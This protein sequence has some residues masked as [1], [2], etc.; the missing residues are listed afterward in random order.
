MRDVAERAGVSLKTVSRVINAEAGVTPATAERVTAAI[1]E[2][3]FERNDLA[4]SLRSGRSSSTLG[5]VIEDVANPFYSA[6][7]Q[8]VEAA[9]R[10]R[11]FLLITASARE[12]AAR[13][14]E[15]VAALLRRRVDALLIVPA[16]PDHRYIAAAS[17][18]PVFL[19]RPPL[20][21]DADTV[22]L[23]DLGGARSA[24]EHLI[25]HGHTRIGCVA[26]DAEL[27]T[28]RQRIT[29]YRE[30]LEAA[31]IEFDPSLLSTGT[32]DV[33]G[34]RAAAARLLA[35]PDERRPTALFTANNRNTIGALHALAGAPAG[36]PRR[37]RRLRA[38]RPARHDRRPRRP[39]EARRA[40]RR[41]RLRPPRRRRAPATDR[42]HPNRARHPRLR[43][44]NTVKPL[45]LPPNQF[46][47]FY[48]GGARIDALRGVPEGEDGRP[49]DWVG[50]TAT[51]WGSETEGLS[52]LEDGTVL[53]DAIAADPEAFLG[54]EH[55]AHYGADPAL[56]VKL[57]DAG[58]RLPVHY[59]PGRPFA[60]QH[61]GLRYGK[62]ES[63]LILEAEPGAAVHV[64][65]KEPLDL[66]TARAW[67]DEQ[68]ADVMLQALHEVPVKPGDGILVP[69]GT[70][71]A[72]GGGILLLEL[73]EPTDLSV[74]VEWKRFGVDSGPE[75]LELGWDT[76]L[77][78]LDRQ[79]ID[80]AALTTPS[81]GML[82][83][84]AD[85]YFRAQQIKPGDTLDQSFS[86]VL[87][88][89]GEGTLGD[90]A[91]RKGSTVLIPFGAGE[92]ATD[93]VEAIR[94]LPPDP[95]AGDGAW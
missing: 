60:K 65:L 70:L 27:Y 35:L 83:K 66:Q 50:S 39:V 90:L 42:D 80:P 30:A 23:D 58:E 54:P 62:T 11:G 4:A 21:I 95:T 14:R 33:A 5:L 48:K 75:H 13:E 72:I 64:G 31:G 19:D 49:E 45:N 69:A 57:L 81:N 29:G 53:K 2:L 18:H 63:W 8:A 40:G 74:L 94:C 87:V 36:R 56:L 7:A 12:D 43:R 86:I 82:P 46:H 41:A 16:G 34:A 26:D 91:V 76:A 44:A 78:S 61:L 89:D 1:A 67:V 24:V 22:L 10:D 38:R 92:I 88:T 59:H 84:E 37:L 3:G 71:H 20:G 68:D 15:L 9:A 79:P 47:R 17:S 55:V 25:A 93:G 51:S 85:P 32:R 6:V 28:M 77:Q 73:Q 52:R